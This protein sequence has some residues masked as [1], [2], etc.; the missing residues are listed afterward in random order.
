MNVYPGMRGH[1]TT[2]LIA[3]TGLAGCGSL[4]GAKPFEPTVETFEG[5]YID[6]VDPNIVAA[7]G[8]ERDGAEVRGLND[9]EASQGLATMNIGGLV[10]A[11]EMLSYLRNVLAR[12]VGV[13][14][15]DKPAIS[16]FIDASDRGTA[17][18]TPDA[19]IYVS[20]GF[21]EKVETEG[22]LAMVLAHEAAHI[23][24]NHFS[25]Q[26]YLDAQRSTVTAISGVALLARTAKDIDVGKD[27]SGSYELQNNAANL[28][29]KSKDLEATSWLINRASDHV[30]G[31]FWSRNQEEAADLLAA[32]LLV[33]AGYNPR[34][35]ADLFRLLVELRAE[36][37]SYLDFLKKRQEIGFRKAEA[38]EGSIEFASN[39]LKSASDT[40]GGMAQKVWQDINSTHVDPAERQEVMNAYRKREYKSIKFTKEERKAERDRY[41]A[42]KQT[43]LPPSLLDGHRAANQATTALLEQRLDDAYQLAK[44]GIEGATEGSAHTRTVLASVRHAQQRYDEA[45]LNLER[46]DPD[47]L[48]S[49]QSF[50]LEMMLHAVKGQPERALAVTDKAKKQFGTSEPFWPLRIQL[51]LQRNAIEQAWDEHDNCS[52]EALSANIRKECAA[53][54]KK[55]PRHGVVAAPGTPAAAPGSQAA[56]AGASALTDDQQPTAS[57]FFDS[58]KDAIPG[59]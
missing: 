9:L 34:A 15:Y 4:P 35:G 20:L 56:P 21:L 42:A 59:I 6:T 41:T 11:P 40:V 5:R 19:E 53:V 25:R 30:L 52:D 1:L 10:D 54:M 32:D 23:L 49:R 31:N 51:Q 2:A 39:L 17:Q 26:D 48:R 33:K 43:R 22:Q 29:D 37:A 28:E 27:A 18:A 7:H 50:E 3:L 24:L 8:R 47:E 45:L 36:E 46:I 38:S 44:R 14:P 57:K 55:I 13:Y 16:I 58:L 12:I